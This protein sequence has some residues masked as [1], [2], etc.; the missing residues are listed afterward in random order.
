MYDS[1]DPMFVVLRA[2]EATDKN[3]HPGYAAEHPELVAA[4][5]QAHALRDLA[6]AVR[7]AGFAITQALP[8]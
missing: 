7:E 5:V 3:F 8:D 6:D 4:L 1:N 2:I